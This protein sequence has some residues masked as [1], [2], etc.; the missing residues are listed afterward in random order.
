MTCNLLQLGKCFEYEIDISQ[1][2]QKSV[3]PVFK[4]LG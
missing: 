4:L 1:V 2:G 3:G